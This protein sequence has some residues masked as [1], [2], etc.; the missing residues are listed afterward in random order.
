MNLKIEKIKELEAA[1][2]A[3][4]KTYDI[5]YEKFDA[6]GF[7]DKIE[8]KKLNKIDSKLDALRKLIEKLKAEVARNKKIWEGRSGDYDTIRD[9]LNDLELFG[10]S[11][12]E[13]LAGEIA[14]I[15]DAVKEQRWADAT[16]ILDQGEVGMGP[17]WKDYQAQKKAKESYDPLRLDFD[18]RLAGAQV[19]E[20]QTEAVTG[21]LTTIDAN[22]PAIDAQT[23]AVDYVEALAMLK[24]SVTELEA[25]EAELTRVQEV[26]V[27]YLDGLDKLAPKL[28]ECSVSEFSSLSEKQEKIATGHAAMEDAAGLNDFDTAKTELDNLIPLVDAF[29]PEQAALTEARDMYERDNPK[30]R[31]RLSAIS[32]SQLGVEPNALQTVADAQSLVDTAVALDDYVIA[33]DELINLESAISVVEASIDAKTYYE[34]RLSEVKS[35]LVAAS[36]SDGTRAYLSAIQTDMASLQNDMETAADVGDFQTALDFLDRLEDKLAEYHALI[37]EKEAAYDKARKDL[38]AAV[39]RNRDYPGF[40]GI[41]PKME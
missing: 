31:N 8:R 9:Q 11:D 24:L 18:T 37:D 13:T 30:I 21:P 17:V 14:G 22:T 40:A 3:K 34:V 4:K 36:V 32:S 35:D 15:P 38:D 16:A 39:D 29:L 2:K 25:A 6:D 7:I 12:A 27:S 20:P 26:H 41:P 33:N 19:G 1:V 10:Y 23:E 28:V 5:L